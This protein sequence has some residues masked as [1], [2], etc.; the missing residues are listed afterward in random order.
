MKN[1]QEVQILARALYEAAE[2]KQGKQ[3]EKVVAAFNDYLKRR[4]IEYYLPKI[5]MT[6]EELHMCRE[7]ILKIKAKSRYELD[8]A[9]TRLIGEL[10]KEKYGQRAV[11]WEKETESGLLGG[12]V[13]RY[14][15]KL[16]DMSLKGRLIKLAKALKK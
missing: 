7:K 14:G 15:D 16:W 13:L 8:E 2:G 10:L 5:L 11:K 3:L 9:I 6:L 12:L 1:N 4:R